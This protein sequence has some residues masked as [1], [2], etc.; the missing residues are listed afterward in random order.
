VQRVA[1]P[2]TVQRVPVPP[3]TQQAGQALAQADQAI[4][5]LGAFEVVNGTHGHRLPRCRS[6][7]PWM[8]KTIATATA[9]TRVWKTVSPRDGNPVA[10]LTASHTPIGFVARSAW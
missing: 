6:P 2:D 8:T 1:E 5:L 9:A 4:E 7:N 3:G 10:T